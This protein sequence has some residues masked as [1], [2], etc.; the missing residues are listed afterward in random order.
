MIFY[1]IWQN[2][3]NWDG[4]YFINIA[5]YGYLSLQEY[6]F[7]PLYPLLVRIFEFIFRDYLFSAILINII[8]SFLSIW[9]LFKLVS[10]EFDKKIA[11]KTCFYLLIFPTSFYLFMAYSESLFL[12]FAVL[13]FYFLKKEKFYLSLFFVGLASLTRFVGIALAFVFIYKIIKKYG[14][15]KKSLIILFS[16]WGT[17]LYCLYLFLEAGNPFAFVAAENNWYRELSAP[18]ISIWYSIFYLAIPF[19]ETY[20]IYVF[21]ELIFT[22]LG[23]G[24]VI[25]SFRFLPKHYF[26]YGAISLLIPLF[27]G[28]LMSMPRFLILIFPIFIILALVKNRLIMNIYTV[29]SMVLLIIFSILFINGFWIS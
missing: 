2:F 5:K 23:L 17:G 22:I 26:I 13:T 11:K 27:T 3:A 15:N 24:L 12:L 21:I 28:T 20:K 25:K 29:A 1:N 10:L 16:F 19:F 4:V 9:F 18:W 14:K 8:F 6:A 7:F